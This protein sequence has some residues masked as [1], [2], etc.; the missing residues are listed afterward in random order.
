M[1]DWQ[2][3]KMYD[4]HPQLTT[5][6]VDSTCFNY[7]PSSINKHH[8]PDWSNKQCTN[9]WAEDTFQSNWSPHY[10]TNV[11][12]G[13]VLSLFYPCFTGGLLICQWHTNC[14]H[15]W[16]SKCLE[17]RH[18]KWREPGGCSQGLSQQLPIVAVSIPNWNRYQNRGENNTNTNLI[19]SHYEDLST[20]KRTI[21]F[22]IF[23]VSL[24]VA[25]S[26]ILWWPHIFGLVFFRL[27]FGSSQKVGLYNFEDLWLKIMPSWHWNFQQKMRCQV[28][29]I[30]PPLVSWQDPP[31]NIRVGTFGAIV[32]L[33]LIGCTPRCCARNS[34]GYGSRKDDFPS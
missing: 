11:H 15:H 28:I 25:V 1:N 19:Q 33:G 34:F 22:D 3:V 26:R 6:E 17:A 7:R 24:F 9:G 30:V 2:L 21:S 12:F 14:W 29:I 4:F 23:F 18:L 5:K 32:L 10:D 13:T 20:W 8:S 16:A 27:I 31:R